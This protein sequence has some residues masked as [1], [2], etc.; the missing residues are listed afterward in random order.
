MGAARS[1]HKSRKER[2]RYSNWGNSSVMQLKSVALRLLFSVAE[3]HMPQKKRKLLCEQAPTLFSLFLRRMAELL[4]IWHFSCA[5]P[6]TRR[7][8]WLRMNAIE[9]NCDE[10][11][12]LCLKGSESRGRWKPGASRSS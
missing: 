2:G 9:K 5:S 1:V 8:S 12:R 7:K 11:S 6:L 4:P 3:R 10:D